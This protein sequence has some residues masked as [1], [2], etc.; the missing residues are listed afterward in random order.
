M[1]ARQVL[2]GKAALYVAIR[3]HAEKHR[4][5]VGHETLERN[6]DPDLDTKA[7]LHAHAFH[8]LAALFHDLFLELEGWDAEGEQA[9]D[10]RVTIEHHGCDTVAHQD[11]GT[12]E[13]SRTC[14]DDRDALPVGLHVRHVR[15]PAA[16]EC[17]I[18]NVF[19]DGADRYRPQAIVERARALAE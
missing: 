9:T 15:L 1:H 19:L 12:A 6:V 10:T 2:A 17:L 11:V 7:E 8:D 14:A 18:G 13:S 5:V 3:A 4:V 16:P